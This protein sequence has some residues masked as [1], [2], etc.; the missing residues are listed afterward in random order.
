MYGEDVLPQHPLTALQR[1][2]GKDVHPDG[3]GLDDA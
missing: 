1:G 3:N 2:A